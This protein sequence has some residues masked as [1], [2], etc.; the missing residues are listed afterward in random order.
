MRDHCKS[1]KS[2]Q[3]A[4]R[5]QVNSPNFKKEAERLEKLNEDSTKALP[6]PQVH[7]PWRMGDEIM[8]ERV[9]ALTISRAIPRLDFSVGVA[10]SHQK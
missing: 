6:R 5:R 7:A 2:N 9:L 1:W 8:F 3:A 10:L 4:T